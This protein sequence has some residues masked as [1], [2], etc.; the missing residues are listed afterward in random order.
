MSNNNGSRY[1]IKSREQKRKLSYY[2]E[3]GC[4]LFASFISEM[5]LAL[6]RVQLTRTH[7]KRGLGLGEE[8][9]VLHC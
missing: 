8:G 2:T 1:L 4:F 5:H 3:S 7:S 9:V 6:W